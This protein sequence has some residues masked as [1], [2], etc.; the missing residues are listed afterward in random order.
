LTR[1]QPRVGQG[2]E[3]DTQPQGREGDHRVAVPGEQRIEHEA[4]EDRR[5]RPEDE[6]RPP[7]SVAQSDEAVVEVVLV[8]RGHTRPP[9]HAPD[10]GE[11]GVEYRYT[12]DEE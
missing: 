9:S 7:V 4:G 5:P 3:R 8:G 1:P 2:G 12:E 6:D 10:D 11:E